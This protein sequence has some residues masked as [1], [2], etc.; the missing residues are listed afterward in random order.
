[1]SD[2]QE[3]RFVRK[4]KAPLV[5]KIRQDSESYFTQHGQLDGA[6]QEFSDTPGSKGKENTKAYV[7]PVSNC[8]FHVNREIRK[9]HE[10]GY[11]QYVHGQPVEEQITELYFDK[12]LP[13]NFV[14]YKPQTDISSATLE[15]LCKKGQARFTRKYDGFCC[16]IAHHDFGWEV[17]SRRMD[18]ITE[19]FP[20][21]IDELSKMEWLKPGTI[22]VGE[23]LCLKENGLDDFKNTSRVCRSKTQESLE[24]RTSGEVPEPVFIVFDILF[25][26][27][28]DLQNKT[29]DERSV[30][31]KINFPTLATKTSNEFIVSVDYFNLTP[32]TWEDL[33]KN[34][35]W[36]GFVIT[37][38]E[39]KPGE[40]FYNFSGKAKRPMG[41][42]KLKPIYTEDVVVYAGLEGGGKR[43]NNVGSFFMKQKH[44][45][46]GEWFD[47]GKCGS[48]LSDESIA[49][50]NKYMK[51]YNLPVIK[52][53]TELKNIDFKKLT[54]FTVEIEYS[55][56]QP[57]TN[58]F[59]YP[60]FKRAR[61][62][63]KPEECEAQRLAPE[64]E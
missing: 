16:L 51:E 37:D 18:L 32:D 6:M 30:T 20:K 1:M 49:E 61:L 47:C 5:W 33:A 57:G 15:K 25:L 46:T 21:H 54:G 41:S 36:E 34:N 59:R 19:H 38:G 14:A 52:K 29:Y 50:F 64:E 2:W 9:K 53:M 12:Y 35:G 48:G 11:V 22:L 27:G 28:D 43:L 58:K 3:F 63:K 10:S 23:M 55:E 62:D 40:K 13:K 4:G 17:Y 39:A 44:P 26:N 56:R 7:D 31:W 60:V 42:H 8:N 24:L 45:E